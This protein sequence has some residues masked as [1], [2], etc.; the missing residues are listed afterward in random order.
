MSSNIT[1][2]LNVT[3]NVE[4][5]QNQPVFSVVINHYPDISLNELGKMFEV[6][7]IKKNNKVQVN[8][9]KESEFNDFIIKTC[10][11]VYWTNVKDKLLWTS[12]KY[13]LK[14]FKKKQDFD[15]EVEIYKYFEDNDCKFKSYIPKVYSRFQCDNFC[16]IIREYVIG[17]VRYPPW[18]KIF[19]DMPMFDLDNIE[20]LKFI[21]SSTQIND[22]K[23]INLSKLKLKDKNSKSSNHEQKIIEEKIDTIMNDLNDLKILIRERKFH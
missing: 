6:D 4:N 15:N 16:A 11:S 20:N 7:Y 12:D 8:I 22:M 5:E 17:F 21:G 18:Y 9:K 10:G 14:V 19:E 3:L 23:Y 1:A 2:L 13:V